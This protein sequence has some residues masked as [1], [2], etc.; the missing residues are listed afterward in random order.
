M[1]LCFLLKLFVLCAL[2]T[3]MELAT[4]K[5]LYHIQHCDWYLL[6][7]ELQRCVML[8]IIRAQNP[9]RLMTGTKPLNFDTFVNVI[10]E[11]K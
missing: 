5:L 7:T 8:M 1:I 4:D 9:P 10:K 2:G 11:S 6:P 3:V